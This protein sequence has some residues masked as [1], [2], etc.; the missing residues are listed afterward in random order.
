MTPPEYEPALV[1]AA[2][3]AALRGSPGEAALHRERDPLYS[4]ADCDERETAFARL[5]AQWFEGLGLDRPLRGALAERPEIGWECGRAIVARAPSARHEGADLR[6]APP[7]R[8]TLLLRLMPETLAAGERAWRLLR[9]E[10]LHVADMLDPAFGYEPRVGAGA[11]LDPGRQERYRVLWD[12][13]VEG[14]LVRSGGAPAAAGA[15]VL[16]E[17]TRAFPALGAEGVA[18]FRR[19]FDGPSCTH[20]DLVA[21][22]TG[23]TGEIQPFAPA[24]TP[25]PA[26]DDGGL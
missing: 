17:F 6:L 15:E 11:P 1:E 20:A 23:A 24:V 2:V 14:R 5:H 21:A 19:F 9:R 22:A 12:A 26:G 4:I 13:Y 8:P 25:G 10:L 18:A 3:L 7:A 16:R